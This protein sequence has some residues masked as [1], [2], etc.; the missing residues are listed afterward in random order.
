MNTRFILIMCAALAAVVS[1]LRPLAAA[2]PAAPEVTLRIHSARVTRASADLNKRFPGRYYSE[3]NP[4]VNL[5][6]LLTLNEGFMLPPGR[7][8]VT[9]D[10]FVDDTYQSLLSTGNEGYSSY[11][12][13]NSQS[14]VSEDG[15]TLL[16]TVATSRTPAEEAGRVFARGSV[17]LRVHRGQPSVAT[18]QLPLTVG[19]ETMV[20]PFHTVIRSVSAPG[21]DT[22]VDV[23]IAVE[24]DASR[25]QKVRVLDG[26]G[27]DLTVDPQ[28]RFN[29]FSSGDRTIN[30]PVILR[31]LPKEPVTLEYTYLEKP[32]PVRIPFEAQVDIG[33]TK[34]GPVE[35]VEGGKAPKRTGARTWPPPREGSGEALPPRRAAFNPDTGAQAKAT[36]AASAKLDKATVDLFSITVAKPAPAEVKGVEWKN[37]PSPAFDASG[38]TIARLMLSTPGANI[39]SVPADGIT[40]TRFEDNKG[41]KLDAMLYREAPSSSAHLHRRSPDGE[42]MLLCLSLASAPTPGATRCTLTGN[43]QA[44]V[45]RGERT[46]TVEKLE[47]RKGETFATGP[48][49]G[50]ITVRQTPPFTPALQDTGAMEV[51]VTVTGPVSKLRSVEFLDS[52]GS[53]MHGHGIASAE[54]Q[55]EGADVSLAFQFPTPPSGPVTLRL[56]YCETD[57]TVQVPFDLSMGIGL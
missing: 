11:S 28:P 8:A 26:S 55:P 36:K 33:V 50:T 47:L 41:G 19:Q 53:F 2:V 4:G 10:T 14:A 1:N 57:E 39:I 3:G 44:K 23:R 32:E 38:F 13:G 24:G 45:A 46:N 12:S 31:A 20:G 9:V 17:Q 16:F 34:A 54:S 25:I 6:L 48:F 22:R 35:P 15:R 21:A 51:G 43:V 56:R 49:K 30:A 29:A 5:Q 18:N 37:P 27:K 42:Q 40:V 52:T 7:D